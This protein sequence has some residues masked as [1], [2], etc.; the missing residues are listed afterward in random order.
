ML[1]QTAQLQLEFLVIVLHEIFAFVVDQM[2][3]IKA[4]N[5]S[6]WYLITLL[7]KIRKNL[8]RKYNLKAVVVSICLG[9]V[10]VFYT[11]I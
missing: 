11:G 2:P 9:V 1:T 3:L 4:F 6:F 5:S 7:C 8:L 10:N